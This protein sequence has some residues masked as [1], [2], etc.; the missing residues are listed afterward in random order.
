[1]TKFTDPAIRLGSA[2]LQ[3]VMPTQRPGGEPAGVTIDVL[4]AATDVP[5]RLQVLEDLTAAIS[6]A[7]GITSMAATPNEAE[8]GQT[9][10]SIVVNWT[11]DKAV[12]SQKVNNV[13]I[14]PSLRQ[15][16][17][18]GPITATRAITLA[19]SDGNKGASRTVTVPFWLRSYRGVSATRTPDNAAILA[20]SQQSLAP[21]YAPESDTYDC[22][23]GRY[24]ILVFPSSWGAAP[25][26][27]LLNGFVSNGFTATEIDL[28]NASGLVVPSWLLA[29]NTIQNASNTRVEW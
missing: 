26:Q 3:H 24:P 23:G 21:G 12:T 5:T 14:G 4:L 27:M 18:P 1:M 11:L 25:T 20:F 28:V 2:T 16:T 19:V 13:E 9:L 10:N 29:L 22:T 17:V 7:P 15:F 8:L 6:P